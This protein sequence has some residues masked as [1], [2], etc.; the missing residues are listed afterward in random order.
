MSGRS[1]AS[2]Q[3]R[4]VQLVLCSGL[5]LLKCIRSSEQTLHCLPQQRI[6]LAIYKGMH[7]IVWQSSFLG[8]FGADEGR[9][10]WVG[11]GRG[12]GR[13]RIQ[14]LSVMY[15][16]ALLSSKLSSALHIAQCHEQL[17]QGME[18]CIVYIVYFT[19]AKGLFSLTYMY[20]VA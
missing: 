10:G 14:M 13:V 17:C 20:I 19:V 3:T 16:M 5:S 6:I 12:G 4:L 7:W 18:A 8:Y 9:G 15:A 1:Q 2:E 11:E